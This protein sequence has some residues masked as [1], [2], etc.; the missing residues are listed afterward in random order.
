MLK[1]SKNHKIAGFLPVIHGWRVAQF[2]LSPYLCGEYIESMYAYEQY[3]SC[4]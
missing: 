3:A 2:C 1:V 4:G